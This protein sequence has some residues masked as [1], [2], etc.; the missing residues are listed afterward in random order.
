MPIDET[1]KAKNLLIKMYLEL[2]F[3]KN[4]EREELNKEK[5]S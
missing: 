2:K 4:N 1:D 5:I 3:R